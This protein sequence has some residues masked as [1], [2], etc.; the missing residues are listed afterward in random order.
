MLP[1][2]G[3]VS[4]PK[5]ASAEDTT[6]SEG[7]AILTEALLCEGVGGGRRLL[8]VA[9]GRALGGVCGFVGPGLRVEGGAGGAGGAFETPFT[10]PFS[11][12]G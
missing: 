4:A 5:L 12:S 11:P 6:S 7:A 9:C 2:S 8:E 1:G 3:V 10:L